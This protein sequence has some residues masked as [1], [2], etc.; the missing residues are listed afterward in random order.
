MVLIA[1]P[2]IPKSDRSFGHNFNTDA[3][4]PPAVGTFGNAA[5]DLI[6]GPGTNNWDVS[7]FKNIPLG[8]ERRK[9]QFRSEFYN[10]FNHTQFSSL[11]TTARFDQRGNQVN[12]GFSQ[13]TA[14]S[15]PRRIQFALR[16]IF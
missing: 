15:A 13:Y 7:A 1:D 4:A 6:R 14:A 11:D 9:L 3:F 12:A 5:K 10:A 8:S 16:F 2:I